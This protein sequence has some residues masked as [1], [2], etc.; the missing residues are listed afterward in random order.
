MMH[1]LLS[2]KN[3]SA[4]GNVAIGLCLVGLGA[5]LL[6]DPNTMLACGIASCLLLV[7]VFSLFA[8]LAPRREMPDEMSMVHDGQA[9]GHAL[10]ITFIAVGV[11]C[12]ASMATGVRV[13][14]SAAGVGFIGLGLLTY[15]VVFGWLE[16]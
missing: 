8:C 16:R 2:L 6:L 15:G 12:A 9:A 3:R 5:A 1:G 14:F 11:A 4:F 13:D 10:R 7:S